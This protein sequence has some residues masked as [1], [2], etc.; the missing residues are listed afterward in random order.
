[1]RADTSYIHRNQ[2]D[3]CL[4]DARTYAIKNSSSNRRELHPAR[5]V[6]SGMDADQVADIE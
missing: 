2:Q 1:M 5:I 3:K 6:L 4:C